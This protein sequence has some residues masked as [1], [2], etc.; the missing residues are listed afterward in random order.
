M[1]MAETDCQGRVVTFD[2]G[3]F[4][5]N[6]QC[7]WQQYVILL[8]SSSNALRVELLAIVSCTWCM[9]F[10]CC[11]S[12]R[13]PCSS[14]HPPSPWTGSLGDCMP[15]HSNWPHGLPNP[16]SSHSSPCKYRLPLICLDAG[17]VV[18]DVPNDRFL[19]CFDV[20]Y[21]SSNRDSI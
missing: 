19:A 12:A 2:E 3:I 15:I 17:A 18:T 13:P 1:V 20:Q 6:V 5:S 16:P 21:P 14:R 4:S 8:D 7:T 10:L 9:G 11:R